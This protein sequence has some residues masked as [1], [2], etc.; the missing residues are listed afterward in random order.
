MCGLAGIISNRDISSFESI[1]QKMNSLQ[2]HRGPDGEGYWHSANKNVYL[3]HRRLAIIDLSD[4]G[5]QPLVSQDTLYSIVYNGEI[6]NY[7]E[8]KEQ[9]IKKGS[10]F[11]SNTDTEVI[12]EYIRH[13]GIEGIKDFRGMWAFVLYDA[14][15]NKIIFSRDPFG[16]KPLYYAIHKD[17]LYFASE[18]KAIRL[19]NEDFNK[20]DEITRQLF[21]DF[22]Y[23]DIGQWTFFKN[24]KRFPQ[25]SYAEIDL[26][27]E[28]KIE[29]IIYWHPPKQLTDIDEETATKKLNDLLKQSITRH[30]V[31]DVPIAFCL[32]GGLDSSTIVGM[33]ATIVKNNNILNSFTT[34]YP[35]FPDIDEMK[36]AKLAVGHTG[37]Q[38]HWIEVQYQDFIK[39]FELVLY[40]HDEPFGSTSVYA[41]NAIF[42]AINRAGLKVSL[43]GQG[44]DEIF[45]GYN[46]YHFFF[47]KYLLKEK[48]FFK[49]LFETIELFIRFPNFIFSNFTYIKR[50]FNRRSSNN[51]ISNNQAYQERLKQIK[52]LL[53]ASS[54]NELLLTTLISSSI[55][56]LLRNGDRNSMKN[57]VESR[58]PFLDV[59]LVNF[60]ISL[61]DHFKI[62]KAIKKYLL[63]QVAYSYLPKKLV[64]R[65]D[66]L[67][68]PSPEKAWMKQAFNINVSGTF[69]KKWREFIVERW[70]NMISSNKNI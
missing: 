3:A 36:W 14:K 66:K 23:L 63:K 1:I 40:H 47:L 57:Q 59:D 31:S 70:E 43:D 18:I 53:Q 15:N 69:T 10:K 5:F 20:V 65:T 64:D 13:F 11:S 50:F 29:P 34:H 6:Y 2:V 60:I 58:V 4:N 68:F 19:I 54:F 37:V 24:I 48:K 51:I 61:P 25:A 8:L 52:N 39:E 16:I 55:P 21:L 27:K 9:C 32:S 35:H 45:A 7:Q 56:Q 67:G 49:F 44:A 22:G 12:I 33:A 28:V 46:S 26:N 38:P 17:C 42:K 41:Q 30:M 62:R